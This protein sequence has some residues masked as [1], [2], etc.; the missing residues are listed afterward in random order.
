[1]EKFVYTGNVY[2]ILK[3]ENVIPRHKPK[4]FN[5]SKRN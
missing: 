2:Y 3:I 4:D 5:P 1:M